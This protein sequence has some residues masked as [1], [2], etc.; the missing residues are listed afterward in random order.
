[1]S[2]AQIVIGHSALPNKIM[3]EVSRDDLTYAIRARNY[4]ARTRIVLAFKR[5]Y[6]VVYGRI[7]QQLDWEG[8]GISETEEST[9]RPQGCNCKC[10][11]CDIGGHCREEQSGC[12]L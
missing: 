3:M 11:Y 2:K 1:M 7:N 9:K 10:N 5:E 12:Y 6:G 4:G 8:F